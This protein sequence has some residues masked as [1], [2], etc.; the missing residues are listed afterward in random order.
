MNLIKKNPHVKKHNLDNVRDGKIYT[1]LKCEYSRVGIWGG[2]RAEEAVLRDWSE[3]FIEK[4]TLK[5]K[6]LK[7]VRGAWSTS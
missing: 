7:E 4:V 6:A 5:G 3:A 2:P 1:E